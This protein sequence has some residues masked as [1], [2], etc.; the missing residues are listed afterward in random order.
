MTTAPSA[1]H[2]LANGENAVI[3][4][5]SEIF[6]CLTATHSLLDSFLSLDISLIRTLPTSYFVQ[7]T[8]AALV[9]VKL[10]FAVTPLLNDADS[11][12][13]LSDIKADAYLERLLTRFRGWGALWPAKRL[14]DTLKRLRDLLPQRGGQ[15]LASEMAWLN[16]W[17]LEDSSRLESL[18]QTEIVPELPGNSDIATIPQGLEIGE[19]ATL[20]T[21]DEDA[22]SLCV[23]S[24]EQINNL[25]TITQPAL[26]SASLDATELVD[27]FG[28]DLNAST[29]DFD[30]NLQSMIQFFG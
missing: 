6:G 12:Q 10:H 13:K 16:A 21:L 17:T 1:D 8:D 9:L 18:E 23:S 7:L 24:T 3:I 14:V 22:L 28:T 29:F 5:S 27:W 26:P 25:Q 19:R 30:G 2:I 11:A 15:E 20:S 4:S